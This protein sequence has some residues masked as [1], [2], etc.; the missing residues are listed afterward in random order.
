MAKTFYVLA[1]EIRMTLSRLSYVF[2]SFGIPLIAVLLYL[3]IQTLA[4]GELA[5]NVLPPP[6]PA[7]LSMEGYVDQA[8]LIRILPADVPAGI[9]EPFS[10][11]NQARQALQA[12]EI[13]A[14]YLIPADYLDSG[15]L[16]YVLGSNTTLNL[17]GQDWIMRKTLILNLAGGDAA[18]AA[19]LWNPANVQVTDLSAAAQA[20]GI[21]QGGVNHGS[22]GLHGSGKKGEEDGTADLS[23][24]ALA[25]AEALCRNAVAFQPLEPFIPESGKLK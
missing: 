2:V 7:E 5:G 24:E 22:H 12:G 21:A 20:G 25:K 10:S 14:Y 11:E 13:S 19:R 15:D 17:G 1:N 18:L 8:G 16:I 9:L 4:G 3:G 6:V 23:A